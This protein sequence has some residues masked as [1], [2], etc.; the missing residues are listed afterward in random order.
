M[1]KHLRANIQAV[2]ERDPAAR[3]KTEVFLAYPGVHALMYYRLA[4]GAWRH[5]W[6]LL[7]R[8]LSHFGRLMTG[9]EIHPGATIG[10]RVFIDHG[11]GVVIGE[12]AEVGDDVTLYQGVTLG[13]TSLEK[14]KRHPTLEK[15][16]IVGGGAMVLGPITIGERA[17][18]GANAVVVKDVPAGV[19]VAGVPAK[20]V[21][22]RRVADKE[23]FLAYGTPEDLPDPV[24]K[25]MDA[26]LDMVH[27]LTLRV[28]QLEQ[29][30]RDLKAVGAPAS[31]EDK[32]SETEAGG[33]V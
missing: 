23:E 1:F 28:E 14:G 18:V 4:H 8:V 25:S 19:T 6:Y 30:T 7:G 33:T 29:E 32:A 16:A 9:I 31:R 13:G 5:K 15:G 21:R 3:S 11:M 12:T 27:R 17:V 2:M 26:M 24:T 10:E 22:G 20:I